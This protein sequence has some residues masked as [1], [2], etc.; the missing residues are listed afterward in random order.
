VTV[1]YRCV[2][3]SGEPQD[4]AAQLVDLTVAGC[5]RIYREKISAE[6]GERP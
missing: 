4:L 6:T 2:R 3:V 1:I 5:E